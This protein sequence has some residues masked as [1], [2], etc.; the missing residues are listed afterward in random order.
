MRLL[1]ILVLLSVSASAVRA[2][3]APVGA[4]TPPTLAQTQEWLEREAPSL[5]G[6]YTRERVGS[7]ILTR[8]MWVTRISLAD[9]VLTIDQPETFD[10][11]Q[12][13][14]VDTVDYSLAIPLRDLDVGGTLIDPVL[15]VDQRGAVR[16]RIRT[17]ATAGK[18]IKRTGGKL[19]DLASFVW[20]SARYADDATRVG[21]AVRRAATLCGA[22]VGPF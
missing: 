6:A 14:K 8:D 2:Q 4:A 21:A 5:L 17:T 9:C 20:L 3:G 16:L 15:D 22:K 10:I 1:G 18:T 19:P 11:R 13:P 7:S 12:S